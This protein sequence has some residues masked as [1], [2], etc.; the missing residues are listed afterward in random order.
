MALKS[1]KTIVLEEMNKYIHN[2]INESLYEDDSDNDS[3]KKIS[4]KQ[5]KAQERID[6]ANKR[7]GQKMGTNVSQEVRDFLNDPTVNVSDVMVQATGLAPTSASSLGAKIAKGERPVKA[8]LAQT[9]HQIQNQ[10]G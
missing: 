8:K 10:L 2:I 1:I 6:R 3:Q 9:V 4:D 7:D 5:R